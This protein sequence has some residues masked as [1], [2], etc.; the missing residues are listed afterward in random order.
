MLK[1]FSGFS[2]VIAFAFLLRFPHVF[3][4]GDIFL[5]VPLPHQTLSKIL[6]PH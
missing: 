5:A 1:G 2:G 6:V 4:Q 3:G